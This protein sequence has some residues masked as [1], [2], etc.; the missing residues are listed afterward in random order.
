[1]RSIINNKGQEEMVGFVLIVALV[2]VGLVVFLVIS[3]RTSPDQDFSSQEVNNLLSSLM[4][5][6][7]DCAIVYEPDY[8]NFAD[9]IKSCSEEKTCSNLNLGAC[10]YLNNTLSELMGTLLETDASVS[11][12]QLD[13][14]ETYDESA[15]DLL[16]ILNGNCTGKTL[17]SQKSIS[18]N[19]KKIDVRLIL[20]YN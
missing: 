18:L 19:D 13:I 16:N 5:H 10:E 20:C 8:D 9:L 17:G 6:T 7:T 11:A 2:M 12:Y 14:S 4:E 3:L 1:M 15:E